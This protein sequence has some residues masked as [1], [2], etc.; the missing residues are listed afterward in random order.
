MSVIIFQVSFTDDFQIVDK[1]DEIV[2]N[3]LETPFLQKF[4]LNLSI[5]AIH[6][7]S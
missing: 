5:F 1:S 2:T 7:W 3:L 4:S 6:I